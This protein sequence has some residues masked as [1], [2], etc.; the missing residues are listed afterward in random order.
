MVRIAAPISRFAGRDL[1]RA[2]AAAAVLAVVAGCG[3]SS[4]GH[5]ADPTTTLNAGL[6]LQQQGHLSEAAQ[7]YQQVIKAQPTD[8]YAQYDLGVVQQ[9]MANQV[10]A[11]AAYGAALT[12]NPK[13]VPALYNEATIYAVSDPA[14][15]ISLYRQ[16]IVLQPVA[17]TAYLNLGFLEIK[18]NAPKAGVRDLATAV[19]QDSTLLSRVPK[20]L[21][22]G[23]S[24]LAKGTKPPPKPH[25]TPST[26]AS[27]PAST[28]PS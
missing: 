18:H 1:G 2:C 20:H 24:A 25:H 15:A 23:V 17:P 27:T 14:S 19:K 12:I 6:K 16:I 3:A 22:A 21:R 9:A 4:N 10:G 7:L 13:Y 8:I 28:P 5:A 11:L 26:P